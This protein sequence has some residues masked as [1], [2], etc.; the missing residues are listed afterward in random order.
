MKKEIM[1]QNDAFSGELEK[2]LNESKKELEVENIRNDKGIDL[3]T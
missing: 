3:L 1:K 2:L